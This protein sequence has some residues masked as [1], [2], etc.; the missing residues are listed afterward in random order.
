MKRP[1]KEVISRA[2]DEE[3]EKFDQ[4]HEKVGFYCF[5]GLGR[6]GTR[7]HQVTTVYEAVAVRLN[8]S[9][10]R[11]REAR[12]PVPFMGIPT[13]PALYSQGKR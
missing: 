3:I 5:N 7:E 6:S 13:K 10:G 8:V 1:S 9:T 2:V 4:H 12:P 11:V